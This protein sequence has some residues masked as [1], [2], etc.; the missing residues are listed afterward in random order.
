MRIDYCEACD[1]RLTE[2]DFDSGKAVRDAGN[3]VYCAA[4]APVSAKAPA[5]A[6]FK[7]NTPRTQDVQ[8]RVASR[9]A[10]HA[11][12][13]SPHQTPVPMA[14]KVLGGGVALLALVGVLYAM[15]GSKNPKSP[16]VAKAD[17]PPAAQPSLEE[18]KSDTAAIPTP[19]SPTDTSRP[20][21]IFDEMAKEHEREIDP[22]QRKIAAAKRLKDAMDFGKK[23]PQDPWTYLELLRLVQSG[24]Q[25]ADDAARIIADLHV[26]VDRTD[27]PG[28]RRDW[29]FAQPDPRP[30]MLYDFD[31]RKNILQT[32]PS[33]RDSEFVFSRALQVPSDKPFLCIAARTED[34][35]ACKI[36]LEIEGKQ[37]ALE[38]L[39][40]SSWRAFDLDLSAFK[41]KT[42]TVQI[43]QFAAVAGNPNAY[44][45][46]PV[47]RAAHDSVASLLPYNPNAPVYEKPKPVAP[48]RHAFV[49]PELWKESPA[50]AQPINLLA[51][52]DLKTGVVAGAWSSGEK[53]AL[54]SNNAHYSRLAIPYKFPAQYD[55]RATFE[56]KSGDSD[57]CLILT[58]GSHPFIWQMGAEKNKSFAITLVGGKKFD[59]NQTAQSPGTCLKNN[60]R[61]TTVVEVRKDRVS[62][63]L[64][65]KLITEW[66]PEMGDLS[67]SDNWKLPA[68]KPLG[69]AAQDS[70]VVFYS[71]ELV[72]LK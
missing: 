12:S 55:V 17:N 37:H 71:L 45:A 16:E 28:W 11:E 65:G 49:A 67:L 50:W 61:Y 30:V 59:G 15:G 63:Y 64:D 9:A 29:T 34:K 69:I 54:Q 21:G 20:H 8:G 43:R 33:G 53:N 7:R 26:P 40:G 35:N 18:H 68:G 66:V 10:T 60:Q 36:V 52:A 27:T 72:E 58:Q 13:S 56:R 23:Y 4:C 70:E 38:E 51:L 47:F 42:A 22:E 6:A 39:K 25:P 1:T 41:G 19:Q 14:W 46:P 24:T 5:T 57:T 32:K 31:G 44:W 62:A 2:E 3:K 48:P